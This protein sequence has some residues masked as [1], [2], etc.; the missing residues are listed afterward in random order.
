MTVVRVPLPRRLGKGR[1]KGKWRPSDSG[2][3]PR[4]ME[5]WTVDQAVFATRGKKRA[6][7]ILIDGSG[8]MSL[9]ADAIR[10]CVTTAPAATMAMY[11]GRVS[12]GF[13]WILAQRGRRVDKIPAHPTG[14][15]VDGPALRWL[16]RQ[17]APRVWVCDEEVTG[18]G[19]HKTNNLVREARQICRV[20]GILRVATI[21]QAQAVLGGARRQEEKA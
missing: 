16:A 6:G 14:N 10:A 1:G 12:E 13:L 2:P 18:L 17:K 21:A 8:S 7:T 19:D 11:S 5:R 15:V 4:R 20:F 9:S 3:I